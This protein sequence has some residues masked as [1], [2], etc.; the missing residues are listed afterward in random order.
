MKSTKKS[1]DDFYLALNEDWIRE[2]PVPPDR[3][4]YC[5]FT[6]LEEKVEHDLRLIIESAAS[7]VGGNPDPDLKKIGDFY[8]TGMATETIETQGLEPI[9]SELDR[10][11]GVSTIADLRDLIAYFTVHRHRSALRP[12]CGG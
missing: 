12:V 6:E 2:H 4:S 9:R 5:A 3:G 10:I 7:N 8:R 11:E 1:C